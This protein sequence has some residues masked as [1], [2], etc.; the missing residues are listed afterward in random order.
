M[1]RKEIYVAIL[2]DKIAKHDA[3]DYAFLF[4]T[5]DDAIAWAENIKKDYEEIGDIDD[6]QLYIQLYIQKVDTTIDYLKPPKGTICPAG[7]PGT[8]A[9]IPT[10][11][12]CQ[13]YILGKFVGE[14]LAYYRDHVEIFAMDG[15]SKYEIKELVKDFVA[16]YNL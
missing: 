14:L 2:I 1:E 9:R 10:L 15:I 11:R 7:E 3:A 8:R 6:N 4:N 12:E 13:K 5:K 16:K